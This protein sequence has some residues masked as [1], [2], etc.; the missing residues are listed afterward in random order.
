[1]N[2]TVQLYAIRTKSGFSDPVSFPTE[3]HAR[4]SFLLLCQSL[5]ENGLEYKS[6]DLF[7]VGDF[8]V[9]TGQITSAFSVPI[10]ITSGYAE[11]LTG[12]EADAADA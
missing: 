4:G 9:S 3:L 1:M 12:K 8:D 10:F 7:Q 5:M 6:Y 2:N 11:N